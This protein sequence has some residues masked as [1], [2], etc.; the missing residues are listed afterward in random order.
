[1]TASPAARRGLERLWRGLLVYG[2]VALALSAVAA[3]AV[4]SAMGRLSA[5]DSTVGS[6]SNQV[7]IVLGRM[8][9]AL[10]DASTSA[11][12]FGAT[13]DTSAA[14]LTGA[15]ED[16]RAIVPQLRAIESQ[17]GAISILG[18][19]PLAGVAGLF[20]QIAGR[21]ENLDGQL[22]AVSTSLTTD[23]SKLTANAASL[24]ELA[25]Q[26]RVLA[27]QL[28]S[29]A[30]ARTIADARVLAFGLLAVVLA[31]AVAPAV[32][33]LGLGWWLREELRRPLSRGGPTRA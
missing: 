14:A 29:D 8:A 10:D 7:T 16:I 25:T 15:A 1:M 13:I 18:S 17:A 26:T 30:L 20:G 11:A 6:G 12:S 21:L 31:A 28:G 24:G 27:G 32:A 22:D 19:Q 4:G 33:A 23:R 3:I 2:V 9:T 5:L